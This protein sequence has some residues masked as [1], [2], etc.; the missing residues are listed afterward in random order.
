M[1]VIVR[2]K[3]S[4]PYCGYILNYE[5]RINQPK[6][7]TS[8]GDKY[9]RCPRCF[10]LYLTGKSQWYE[11][12]PKEKIFYYVNMYFVS[13]FLPSICGF[14]FGLLSWTFL[15]IEDTT[16]HAIVSISI[17]GIIVIVGFIILF[18]RFR[19]DISESMERMPKD[20]TATER[21][22]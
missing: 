11:K 21:G 22:S 16:I 20:S 13:I 4:C 19:A 1:A 6:S 3:E 10:K 7:G 5:V 14:I 12:S 2:E 18:S 9:A 17:C 15:P 8:I